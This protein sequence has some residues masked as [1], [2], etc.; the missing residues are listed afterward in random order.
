M[1][2]DEADDLAVEVSLCLSVNQ[3]E[4]C[5]KD[6]LK[7][8]VK[9]SL[10]E[11]GELYLGVVCAGQWFEINMSGN[12]WYAAERLSKKLAKMDSEKIES[13]VD[14]IQAEA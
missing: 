8:T 2:D 10:P 5:G 9:L 13:I 14:E 1:T 7:R 6:N 4:C 3:C 12:P 11:G